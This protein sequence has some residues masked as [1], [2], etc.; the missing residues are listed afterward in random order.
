MDERIVDLE[1]R[2]AHQDRHIQALDEVVRTFTARVEALE[3][4]LQ[5]LRGAA[6]PPV[7][8]ADDPPP[9]Y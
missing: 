7:G 5:G 2:I 1:I 6:M 9:H 3:R 4:Q 8:P